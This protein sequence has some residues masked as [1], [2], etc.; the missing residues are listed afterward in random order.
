MARRF[1]GKMNGERYLGEVS[2]KRLHDLDEE[3]LDCNIDDILQG[4][5]EQPFKEMIDA[6]DGGY[7]NCVHCFKWMILDRLARDA[8]DIPMV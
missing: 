1:N 7:T 3:S 4:S 8:A 6:H 2:T 5:R